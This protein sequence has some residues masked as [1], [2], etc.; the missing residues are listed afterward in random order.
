MT[1]LDTLLPD[2][3]RHLADEQAPLPDLVAHAASAR[4]RYRRQ[5]R[6]WVAV[7][8]LAAAVAAI[9]VGVPVAMQSLASAPGHEVADTA[10]TTA[11]SDRTAVEE[12]PLTPESPA[13]TTAA[14]PTAEAPPSAEAP[15]DAA[16]VTE[17]AQVLALME[18][19]AFDDVP[20]DG[21]CSWLDPGQLSHLMRLGSPLGSV[22]G[23]AVTGNISGCRFSSV[24]SPDG[25]DS[26]GLR[27]G[28]G[29]LAATPV[30]DTL[31]MTDPDGRCATADLP[32]S[33]AGAM[34]Q[35]CAVDGAVQWWVHAPAANGDVY[36][37][38]V[39]VEDRWT[40]IPGPEVVVQFAGFLSR[41]W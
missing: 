9:V 37:L 25:T 39:T 23:E 41:N 1:D 8:G 16:A 22:E 35:R 33:P 2:R 27:L 11:P 5:R 40:G 30:A 12:A 26:S 24:T 19:L 3:L 31:P 7:T 21:P 6:T 15:S 4:G 28:V 36:V 14:P 32:S 20:P 17:L 13:P 34:L 38:E 29:H 18:P 10:V